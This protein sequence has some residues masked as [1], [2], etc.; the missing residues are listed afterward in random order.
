MVTDSDKPKIW[1]LEAFGLSRNVLYHK[2]KEKDDSELKQAITDILSQPHSS[3]YGYRRVTAELKRQGIKHNK[4]KVLRVMKE[5]GL[6]KKKRKKT[7]PK[8]TDSRHRLFRYPNRIK[9]LKI[10][11]SI[12]VSDITYLPLVNGDFVYLA[13]IMD[14]VTRKI[15]G[16]SLAN[17]LHRSLCL[18]ALNMAL[19]QN[20]P[21]RYHHSDRGVQYCSHEYINRLKIN[22]II[23]SMADVGVSVDNPHAE[24]L[25]GS[26]KKE[27]V[28]RNEYHSMTEARL[29]IA[30]YIHNY[31]H[32]RLH[33]SLDYRTPIEAEAL[34]EKRSVVSLS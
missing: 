17:S 20:K 5:N 25:N 34:I 7:K 23:P 14:Q 29:A 1:L 28:Y 22:N 11:D 24:A 12:W 3:V 32:Y 33:S 2:P 6:I 10:P 31:N 16:W 4:K 8:T 18:K 9:D 30:D 15:V 27:E 19:E 26:I 21:P 13:L